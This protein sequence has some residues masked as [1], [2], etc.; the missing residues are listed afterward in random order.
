M[1]KSI[2]IVDDSPE[3]LSVFG[4]VFRRKGYEV[5]TVEESTT[6]MGVLQ[7][8]RPDL[9]IVDVMM[10][11]IN[12]IDLCRMIRALPEHYSTP[13]I[14]VSAYSDTGIVEQTFEAGANDYVFKPVDPRELV[15]KV[16]EILE[17]AEV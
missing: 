16:Q 1:T 2:M 14:I 5:I 12:G 13:V 4:G 6:V 3:I 8:A 17:V 7:G 11:E 15:A 9:F 10:P